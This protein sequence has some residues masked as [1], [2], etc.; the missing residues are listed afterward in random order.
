M[1]KKAA[2]ATPAKSNIAP[3]ITTGSGMEMPVIAA[4]IS[5]HTRVVKR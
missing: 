2:I 3:P 1:S 4:S 5:D